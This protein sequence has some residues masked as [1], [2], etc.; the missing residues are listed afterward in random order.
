MKKLVFCLLILPGFVLAQR[1]MERE[2]RPDAGAIRE[3][4]KAERIAFITEQL[5]LT[6]EEAQQF[7]PIYNHFTGELEQIRKELR[8]IRKN[9]SQNL[10]KF[11]D[12]QFDESFEAELKLLQRQNE[13]MRDNHQ[14][15]RK[16][17]SARK[18]AQLYDSEHKFRMQLMKRMRDKSLPP[19]EEE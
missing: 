5:N 18:V 14:Q 2:R 15:I 16:I 1:G 19:I 8:Q 11:T 6:A 12:K 7:W 3:R 17:L 13:L 4:I 10:D 9:R